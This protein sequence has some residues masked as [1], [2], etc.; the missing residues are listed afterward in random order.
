MP[1]LQDSLGGPPVREWLGYERKRRDSLGSTDSIY[2]LAASGGRLIIGGT[3]EPFL[4]TTPLAHSSK[5]L[6]AQ[7]E[8]GESA[9]AGDMCARGSYGSD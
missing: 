7:R 4:V 1:R 3:F 5:R 6:T 2:A 9:A 8:F